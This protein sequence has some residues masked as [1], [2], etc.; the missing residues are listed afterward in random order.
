MGFLS[1]DGISRNERIAEYLGVNVERVV[2]EGFLI[3]G[4]MDRFERWGLIKRGV[5][6][7]C[8]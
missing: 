4:V 3:K 5:S 2:G 7:L 8:L 1:V 6:V